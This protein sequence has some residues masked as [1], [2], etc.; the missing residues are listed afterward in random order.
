RTFRWGQTNIT[1]IDPT[2][3]DLAWWRSHW[4]RTHT[5]GVIVNAGGIVAYYP[6]RVPLHR[7]ARLL[8]TRDLFG[9]LC[10]AAH[11]DGL[12]VFARMD[13]NR[14]HEECYRAHPD[15]F[16]CDAAGQPHKAGDLFVSCINGPYYDEHIPAI[17]REIAQ[18]YRPEGFTDNS[19]SGLGRGTIC[20]CA[21]CRRKFRE[22][23]GPD[24]PARKDWDDPAYRA[25]IRWS[26]ARRLEVWELNNR[27]TKSAGGPDCIW[28]GMNSGSV[29]SSCQSFRDL[30][31]ICRRADI[32]ML[33][34]QARTDAGGFQHNGEAGKLIHGL[35]GWDKLAPESMAMYQAGR[36][37]FRLASKPAAEARMWML[38]GIAGGL[39]PWW[40]HVSA[41]HEDRRMY[42]TAG[43]VYDWHRRHERFLVNRRPVATVGV[44]WSQQ[45][46]DFFGRDDVEATVELPWRGLTHAL[47]RARI[48]YLPVH[49]DHIDRDAS[50]FAALALPNLGA[51][52]EAQVAA[53]RRFVQRGGGLLATGESLLRD[54]WGDPRPDFALADLLGAHV[55][56][57]AGTRTR[58]AFTG[59]SQHTY[60]RLR[61]ERRAVVD[62]PKLG[63]EPAAAGSRSAVLAGFDATDLL[64][65]GGRLEPLRVDRGAEV[66]MTFVP[67][68]P[69]YPPETAWM[70]EPVTDIPGLIL[71][72]PAG[73]GRVAFLPAD[74]DRRFARDNL[75]DH[76]DLLANLVRWVARDKTP[77]VVEG[78][79]MI[80]C[81]LYEQEG[82]SILHLVN[83]TSAGTWRQ[84][85]HE[86][87]PVGPIRVR[88][89]CAAPGNAIA[90]RR[91]VAAR[92]F[93]PTVA[94]GW[95]R[96]EI[97]SI[98]DHEVIVLG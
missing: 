70:R 95:C 24:L 13:S 44:V 82:R 62:G 87:I 65:F 19:W 78:P 10:R 79:G 43:P 39:Q 11:D 49:A 40:H 55:P 34:H 52:S 1:E 17:L 33:D 71:T 58:R 67:A 59:D 5:Q 56:E 16:A 98:L 3:Y 97:D 48:P 69:I 77:L 20:H 60:L 96:F 90:A 92:E 61:P 21:N 50:R 88:V 81:H 30:A 68:F 76:G 73:S 14:A 63:T 66:L 45:N 37:A 94:E 32:V 8:G 41:Y 42:Q 26:Y 47:I 75:P 25:W 64:P 84:P 72:T 85:V 31:E 89:Q 9:E 83:L 80:D 36:P 91:L 53:L 28:A 12:A 7:P 2:R 38:D 51:V 4:R 27:V 93:R 6:S 35:L 57:T 18:L 29:A 22:H 23:A 86:L 15:W 46:H 74:L 54:E